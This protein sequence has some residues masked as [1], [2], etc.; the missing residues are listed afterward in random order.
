MQRLVTKRAARLCINGV[1]LADTD[2][3]DMTSLSNMTTDQDKW[4][5]LTIAQ[6]TQ[7][8]PETAPTVLTLQ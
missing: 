1:T 7:N 5:T 6:M 2:S 4:G 8:I 3:S